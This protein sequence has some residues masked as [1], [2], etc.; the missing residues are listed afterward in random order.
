M[1]INSSTPR[2]SKIYKNWDLKYGNITFGNPAAVE[3]KIVALSA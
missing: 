3:R 1:D 2:P